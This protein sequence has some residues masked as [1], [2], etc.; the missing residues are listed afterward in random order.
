MENQQGAVGEN[1]M[2][3]KVER[4]IRNIG[5]VM[6]GK[7]EAIELLTLTM[8]C[9]GHVLIEDVPGT[10]KTTLAIALA[11][12]IGGGFNR[13]PARRMS[14]LRISQ[15]SQCIILKTKSSNIMRVR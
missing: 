9:N 6:V 13:I 5:K 10:G 11:K 14:C 8:L 3:E 4:L 7:N 1:R 2:N 12:S 15:D